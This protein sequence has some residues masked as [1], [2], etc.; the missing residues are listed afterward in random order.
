MPNVGTYAPLTSTLEASY[1]L[2]KKNP[3]EVSISIIFFLEQFENV[4]NSFSSRKKPYL[5]KNKNQYFFQVVPFPAR[6]KLCIP[7][8]PNPFLL[9]VL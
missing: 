3:A 9:S 1:Y 6:G 2:K 4:R 8:H 5:I 7:A